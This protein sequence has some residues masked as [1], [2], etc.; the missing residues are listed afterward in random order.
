MKEGFSYLKGARLQSA[1]TESRR[2]RSLLLEGG[3]LA[4]RAY[5]PPI[6]GFSYLKGARFQS[7]PTG[8]ETREGFP[9]WKGARL[10]SAPTGV[11]TREGSPT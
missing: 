4:K 3:A 1:P 5:G 2:G 11:E 10:Q 8:V 6:G 7:A 9:T